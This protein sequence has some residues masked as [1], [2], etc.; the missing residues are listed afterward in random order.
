MEN[1]DT[2]P[3]RLLVMA[4]EAGFVLP[5][6]RRQLPDVEVVTDASLPF[7]QAVMLSSTAVYSPAEGTDIDESA[8]L[9]PGHP[10]AKAEADFARTCTAA[11][12]RGTVLRCAH[13]VGTGMQGLP[14][15]LARK[16][17]RGTYQHIKN[18]DER[19]SV[20]HAADVAAAVALTLDSGMTLNVTD[21]ADPTWHDFAEALA[22]RINQKRIMSIGERWARW[23]YSGRMLYVLTHTLTYS[24]SRLHGMGFRPTPVCEYLRNHVYDHQSL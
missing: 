2:Q 4:P 6:I 18:R 22:W 8:E 24:S 12:V 11:G 23:R 17:D 16:I 19:L 20:I 5:Y 3:T 1:K 9:L 10:L 15:E 13:I 14:M 21:G 7:D